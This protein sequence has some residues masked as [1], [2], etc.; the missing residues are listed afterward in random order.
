MLANK[1]AFYK[2]QTQ[3]SIK[4]FSLRYRKCYQTTNIGN[5]DR[6]FTFELYQEK[7]EC[8]IC[9]LINSNNYQVAF[10]ELHKFD[11]IP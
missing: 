7:S 9:F 6:S 10:D 4:V 11:R 3:F 2:T 5:I 8:E 1:I